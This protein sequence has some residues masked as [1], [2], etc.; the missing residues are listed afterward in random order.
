M[1]ESTPRTVRTTP[2]RGERSAHL[3]FVLGMTQHGTKLVATVR[4]L[5]LGAVSTR[6]ALLPASTELR[7][8]QRVLLFRT[9]GT[10]AGGSR[11]VVSLERTRSVRRRAP[12]GCEIDAETRRGTSGT[13]TELKQA[14][15]ELVVGR[16]ARRR[17][18]RPCVRRSDV[19]CGTVRTSGRMMHGVFGVSRDDRRLRNDGGGRNVVVRRARPRRRSGW[20]QW[21][22][23]W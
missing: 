7:L 8:V 2:L 14:V 21:I 12:R 19:E 13:E 18:K 15:D 1:N 20:T 17:L 3:R 23:R 4:E 16:R 10:C 11:A 5:T 22:H 6:A 9:R